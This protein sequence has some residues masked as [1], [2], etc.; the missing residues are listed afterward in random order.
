MAFSCSVD[1]D[2][3]NTEHWVIL[4][5]I[6]KAKPTYEKTPDMVEFK[7]YSVQNMLILHHL[8]LIQREDIFIVQSFRNIET[9]KIIQ[10]L[11]WTITG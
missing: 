10:E 5:L 4:R 9:I 6:L 3:P 11:T 2:K 1:E 7:I 8:I